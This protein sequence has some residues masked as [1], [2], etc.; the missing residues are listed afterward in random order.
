M[1]HRWF[2]RLGSALLLTCAAIAGFVLVGDVVG[3]VA[4]LI[5]GCMVSAVTFG[6]ASSALDYLERTR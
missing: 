6:L 1:M 4:G 5:I 2:L 3:A